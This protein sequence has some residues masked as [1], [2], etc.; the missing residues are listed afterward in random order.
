[1]LFDQRSA[2]FRKTPGPMLVLL[3]LALVLAIATVG[4]ALL[5]YRAAQA[6]RT[7]AI[8]LV[9]NR[10]EEM[11]TLLLSAI[12]KDMRGVQES[13]LIP[14]QSRVLFEVPPFE[15]S[16]TFSR[17]FA[18]FPYPESFFVWKAPSQNVAPTCD[19]L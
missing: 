2:T 12:T 16:D 18:R 6:W 4:L 5:G 19:A 7:S 3:S 8:M 15:L 17:G 1:M 14:M 9:E 13:I 10:T 11:A